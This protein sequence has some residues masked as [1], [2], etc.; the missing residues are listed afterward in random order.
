M[1]TGEDTDGKVFSCSRMRKSFVQK[2]Y[3]TIV[4]VY[5]KIL[6]FKLLGALEIMFMK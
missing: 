5:L 4:E 6:S 2:V 1:V 3:Q